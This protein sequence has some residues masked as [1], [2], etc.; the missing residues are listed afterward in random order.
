MWLIWHSTSCYPV[1][2]A[3][4]GQTQNNKHLSSLAPGIRDSN[5]KTNKTWDACHPQT[6]RLLSQ[7]VSQWLW[8]PTD[9]HKHSQRRQHVAEHL[10]VSSLA[11]WSFSEQSTEITMMKS[12]STETMSKISWLIHLLEVFKLTGFCRLVKI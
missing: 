10:H 9:Y 4:F 1:G 3:L 2:K 7:S 12:Q 6:K 8:R 11:L 5:Y